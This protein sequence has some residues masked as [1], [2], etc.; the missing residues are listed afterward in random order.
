MAKQRIVITK[1]WDDTYIMK[2]TPTEK[3]LFLYFL[4]NPLTNI[5]GIYEISKER[6]SF[7][8]G[9]VISLLE[10]ILKRFEKDKKAVYKSGWICIINFIKNQNL[11]PDVIKGIKREIK[12]IPKG[13]IFT[14]ARACHS[15]SQDGTLNL[16]KLNLTKPN[17]INRQK[18]SGGNDIELLTDYFINLT[19]N[20]E[21]PK[22]HYFAAGEI[23]TLCNNSLEVAKQQIN[24]TMDWAEKQGMEW[25]LETVIKKYLEI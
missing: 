20:E 13:L 14:F 10:A 25:K 4:T 2:L 21:K 1:F 18:K 22:R 16:T 15:L 9:I 24:K 23:L 8:T 19:G 12:L 17:G 5:S 6:I 11:N 7:D 3:L